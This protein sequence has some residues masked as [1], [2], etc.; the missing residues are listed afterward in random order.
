ML[1]PPFNLAAET[2]A[3]SWI[4]LA[5]T[6]SFV[7]NRYGQFAI[8]TDDLK[9]MAANFTPD[10]TPIDYDHTS[11]QE[12]LK[13]GDGIAAGW[14][15]AVELRD[16]GSTLW[17]RVEWTPEAEQRI[18]H[19]EY[20]FV[21]PSFV[22]DYTTAK[23]EKVGTKLLA[24]AL[25]NLP[26][27][28]E[29]AAVTLGADAVFGQFALSVPAD[30]MPPVHHLAEIGQRVT[31]H[32]D[33]ER[34][35][36]LTDEER[37]QMFMVKGAIG[38]GD[39]AFVRLDTVNGEAF[40]WFRSTQLAPAAAP[41]TEATPQPEKVKPATTTTTTETPIMQNSDIEKKAAAF[42]A[43]LPK[44]YTSADAIRL[45]RQYPEEA[46]AYRLSGIGAETTDEPKPTALNLSVRSGETFDQLAMRYAAEKNIPLRQAVHEVGKA[47][48]ELAATR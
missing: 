10:V 30:R 7:S 12:N 32:P 22:K 39:D 47:R 9:M 19:R 1:N 3:Q 40:G 6:G 13:P 44:D 43:R 26:F 24:A 5:R 14:L 18:E 35:P 27:L 2:P 46:D 23:G 16:G 38:A 42:A 45:S 37:A 8:T 17:G 29:M 4:Q 15:K 31:F 36:E 34:T 20:R 25:T 28:P 21:S 41:Q 33:P 11:M 48:P